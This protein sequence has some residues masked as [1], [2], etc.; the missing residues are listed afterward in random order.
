LIEVSSGAVNRQSDPRRRLFLCGSLRI[1]DAGLS[2]FDFS[3]AGCSL[4]GPSACGDA[5][6]AG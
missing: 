6:S 3:D 5:E 4:C 1:G 2:K